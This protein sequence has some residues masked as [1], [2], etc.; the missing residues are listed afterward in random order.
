MI[1]LSTI[2]SANCTGCIE[3]CCQQ[4]LFNISSI[5][6]IPSFLPIM[7][8]FIKAWSV[9]SFLWLCQLNHLLSRQALWCNIEMHRALC[10]VIKHQFA[11]LSHLICHK[12][13]TSKSSDSVCLF[14]RV[15]AS[16]EFGLFSKE[17]KKTPCF[18]FSPVTKCLYF[19]LSYP[20]R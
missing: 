5:G 13:D 3:Q 1:Y 16:T 20:S 9:P 18:R 12:A 19:I 14:E 10:F 17:I 8:V 11:S 2:I 15:W 4:I 7:N 6:G